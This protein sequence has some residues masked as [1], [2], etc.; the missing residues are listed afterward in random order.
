[1]Q[2]NRVGWFE[3]YANDIDRARKFYEGVFG[4]TLEKLESPDGQMVMWAFPGAMDQQTHGASGALVH[5]PGAPVGSGGTLVYFMSQDCAI[6]AGRAAAHGGK[7]A[8]EK[9]AI[10]G[11]YGFAAL[12]NDTE[13]NTFG[14]HSME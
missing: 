4:I 3:I 5:M 14:V 2:N 12:L 13:G 8:M 6:E 10:G 7:V 11:D 1:M 9:F